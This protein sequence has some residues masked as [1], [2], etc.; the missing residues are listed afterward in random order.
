MIKDLLKVLYLRIKYRRFETGYKLLRCFS[1]GKYI[2]AYPLGKTTTYLEN[3]WVERPEDCGPL[4]VF[5]TY[6]NALD[7]GDDIRPYAILE[8][9]YKESHDNRLWF[10]RSWSRYVS[11]LPQG[12]K[13]ADKL[14]L[15]KKIR[16]KK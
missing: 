12:T 15:I 14:I 3:E 8:C 5:D 16:Q 2:S 4:A 6:E 11:D 9:K 1:E 10:H 13:F 7:F